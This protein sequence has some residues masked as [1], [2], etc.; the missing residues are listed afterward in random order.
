MD[1]LQGIA[2]NWG[3]L[4]RLAVPHSA[5]SEDAHAFA[6]KLEGLSPRP[7]LILEVTTAIG[8][9]IGPGAIGVIGL[10]QSK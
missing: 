6:T 1:Q 2:E 8:A 10:R 7:P 9:H 5:S 4:D 3:N